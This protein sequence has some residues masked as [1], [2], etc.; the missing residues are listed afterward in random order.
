LIAAKLAT[1]DIVG[2]VNLRTVAGILRRAYEAMVAAAEAIEDN[3]LDRR[4]P[5]KH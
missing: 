2:V 5:A 3:Q 1:P 4:G